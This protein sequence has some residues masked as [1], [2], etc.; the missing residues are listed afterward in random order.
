VV[1]GFSI[2]IVTTYKSGFLSNSISATLR[3]GV[4]NNDFLFEVFWD[5]GFSY[6]GGSGFFKSNYID[7]LFPGGGVFDLCFVT[8][9]S[10]SSAC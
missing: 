10:I 1:T 7:F 3:E 6:A 2:E 4:F 8:T 5:T 9:S